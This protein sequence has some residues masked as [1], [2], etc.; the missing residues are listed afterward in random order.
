[1][2]EAVRQRGV[3]DEEI[4]KAKRRR[5]EHE[6][7][8]QVWEEEKQRM[9][10]DQDGLTVEEWEQRGLQFELDQIVQRARNRYTERRPTPIDILIFT[11]RTL[12][13]EEDPDL[14]GPDIR[15]FSKLICGLSIGDLKTLSKDI[16]D[17]ISYDIKNGSL[18]TA[19]QHVANTELQSQLAAASLRGGD[20]VHKLVQNDVDKQFSTKTLAELEAA[21][22]QIKSQLGSAQPDGVAF[23]M[24]FWDSTLKQIGLWKSKSMLREYYREHIS[25]DVDANELITRSDRIL[26]CTEGNDDE[27]ELG[28]RRKEGRLSPTL[29]PLDTM[30]EAD[31]DKLV[32]EADDARELWRKR[33]SSFVA[34]DAGDEQEALLTNSGQKLGEGETLFNDQIQV[35]T[36]YAWHDKYR[37]R[38]PK[39][40]NK[41]HTGFEWNKY[42]ST[43]FDA[44]NPP[45]KRVLGYKFN[46]FYPDLASE[47]Q[48]PVYFK[49]ATE[50]GWNDDVC[51]LRF[52]AGPPYEDIA[53]KIVN[54][55]WDK[56]WRAGYTFKFERGVL[57]LHFQF[58][59]Y[60]YRR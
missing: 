2:E 17:L 5:E 6:A 1:M 10:A 49:E 34:G 46:V 40:F 26:M 28:L 19:M 23:D 33:K 22:A 16:D 27:E 39:Y 47:D 25:D 37:P 41:V 7:Q 35:R 14:L 53:F 56:H 24:E 12:N 31:I 57:H 29:K 11:L 38:K 9:R 13:K 50:N 54:K 58:V 42:N 18:W 36:S 20:G 8:Q 43:H 15:D 55:E 45:P 48:Q 60:R 4:R 52:S 59:R 21:E 44:D 51:I 3:M 32:G 30:S